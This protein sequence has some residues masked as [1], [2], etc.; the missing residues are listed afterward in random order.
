M[1][2][3]P[4]TSLAGVSR[5]FFANPLPEDDGLRRAVAACIAERKFGHVV[6]LRSQG[7]AAPPTRLHA[8]VTATGARKRQQ[9]L[10][11]RGAWGVR[12]QR[13]GGGASG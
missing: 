1:W 10:L 6:Q 5:A 11:L 7:E 12:G 4:E 2:A 3:S 8:P 9:S 13:E